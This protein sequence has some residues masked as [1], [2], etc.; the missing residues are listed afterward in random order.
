MNTLRK[1]MLGI[2]LVLGAIL[3][4]TTFASIL[5]NTSLWYF[6]TFDF[7]RLQALIFLLI[8]LVAYFVLKRKV[9]FNF[10]T[11]LIAL[12]MI[13]QLYYIFRYLPFSKKHVADVE[14]AEGQK[15]KKLSII[16]AN[17]YMKNRQAGK[18]LDIINDKDP[19]FVLAMEVDN[20]WV[21]QLAPLKDQFPH[22]LLFPTNNT[23]GMA[24]YSKHP[25]DRS[26]ILY[27]NHDSVPSFHTIVNASQIQ[28]FQLLTVH[29]VAPRPSK[30]PDNLRDEEVGLLKAGRVIA[31]NPL[32]AIVAGDFNDVGWS[33]N[34]RRFEEISGLK[35]VRY[36]R[37]FYNTFSAH[38]FFMRWPLDY[39][40][41]S[42]Q[43]RISE[44]E[45]LPAFGS[46]HFPLLV[47]FALANPDSREED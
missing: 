25:F 34:S 5:Y 30:H 17:V 9:R 32:P 13:V 1:V 46:D 44:I 6:K 21:D 47:T 45:R 33:Y 23:Y 19:D 7:P 10:F 16:I 28:P 36:G 15:L 37:G 4:L 27:F 42:P 22:T 3:I 43:F 26:T 41:T 40:Y 35:D 12:S 39:V 11:V 20:W 29:P 24:L 2:V 31:A 18:F 8:I 14:E 38:S